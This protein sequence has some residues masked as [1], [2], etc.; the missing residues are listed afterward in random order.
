MT[1]SEVYLLNLQDFSYK[2]LPNMINARHSHG[3]L[4][5]NGSVYVYG[6]FQHVLLFS[7]ALTKC[8]KFNLEQGVWEN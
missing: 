5:H 2:V 8:E 3:S 4:Y 1:T 6:G 7:T